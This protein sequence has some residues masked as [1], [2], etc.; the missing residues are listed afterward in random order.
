MVD[1]HPVYRNRRSPSSHVFC[2]LPTRQQEPSAGSH[3]DVVVQVV[4]VNGPA[5]AVR[6]NAQ[7]CLIQQ[8]SPD[9]GSIHGATPVI[10]RWRGISILPTAELPDEH[11]DRLPGPNEV[12]PVHGCREARVLAELSPREMAN[13]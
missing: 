6:V 3:I 12:L 4:Q 8:T 2:V 10:R 1:H 9:R 5:L 13:P 7:H 11:L